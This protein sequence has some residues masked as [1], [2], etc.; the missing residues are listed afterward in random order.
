[1]SS[2]K[3]S[4]LDLVYEMTPA[5][6]FTPSDALRRTKNVEYRIGSVMPQT[7]SR[8]VEY[9]EGQGNYRIA[10]LPL[11]I[12]K[13]GS[14]FLNSGGGSL[15]IGVHDDG[16]VVGVKLYS[17]DR[18]RVSRVVRDEFRHFTPPV[19]ADLFEIEFVPC[20]KRDYF[21]I[22]IH[23][24]A[25]LESEIYADRQNSMYIR[26]DGSVQGPLWPREI[27]QIVISQY[28]KELGSSS[29]SNQSTDREGQKKQD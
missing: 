12:Q 28:M 21:V 6:P 23:V 20:N 16:T 15:C 9:K 27:R 22:Q 7:E 13:Y 19:G 25:G 2:E 26:R 4:H 5:T 17:S 29:G 24:R 8:T 10:V 1:M 11:H 14:A 3:E 18:E